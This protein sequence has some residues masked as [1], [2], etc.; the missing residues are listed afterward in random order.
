MSIYC[1]ISAWGGEEG[2]RQKITVKSW[3]GENI[4]SSEAV[5]VMVC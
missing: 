5:V 2:V 3:E 1:Y 4:F